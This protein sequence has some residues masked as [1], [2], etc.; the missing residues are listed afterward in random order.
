MSISST[1]AALARALSPRAPADLQAF[2][3]KLIE[4][5]AYVDKARLDLWETELNSI[6]K[7]NLYAAIDEE[8]TPVYLDRALTALAAARVDAPPATDF[9]LSD[10]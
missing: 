5:P 6:G 4:M 8:E 9:D 7:L 3:A 10:W 1:V 2:V